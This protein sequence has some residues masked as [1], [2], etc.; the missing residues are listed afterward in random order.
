MSAL[1]AALFATELYVNES[2]Q[3][4]ITR[5]QMWGGLE[6][7]EVSFIALLGVMLSLEGQNPQRVRKAWENICYGVGYSGP[8]LA[9]TLTSRKDAGAWAQSE[10]SRL[11]SKLKDVFN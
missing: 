9:R 5:G 4:I 8:S 10:M 7:Q 11:L 3:H 2:L 6:A 1:E